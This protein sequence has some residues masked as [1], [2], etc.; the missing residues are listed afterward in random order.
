MAN[1]RVLIVEDQIIVSEEIKE[2]LIAKGYKVIGQCTSAEE[3]LNLLSS[4]VCDVAILDI[5]IEGDRDGIELANEILKSHRTAIIFL[6]AYADEQF[7]KRAKQVKPAAYIVK[8]FEETNLHMAVEVAFNNLIESGVSL[9]EGSFQIKDFIFIKD[10]SR[11][12]KI[13]LDDIQYAEADGSYTKVLTDKTSITLAINL[14]TFES[15]LSSHEF[16]RIHRSYVINLK[17][18]DEYEGN[19]VFIKQESIPISSSFKEGFMRR[20]RFL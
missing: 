4:E 11:Y 14:K 18:I 9:K 10:Q 20:F 3:A 19:R 5:N 16:M 17:K 1:I 13:K 7:L 6:T 2:I 8:P 15:Q 12:R